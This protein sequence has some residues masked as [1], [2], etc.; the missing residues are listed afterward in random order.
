MDLY[1]APLS[2]S[3]ATRIALYESGQHANFHQVVLSTKELVGGGD[4]YAINPKGQVPALRLDDGNMLTEG[5]AILQYV[6]DKNPAAKLAP[7]PGSLARYQLQQWLNYI[8]TEIHKALFYFM[9]NPASPPE[10][11][12][13]VRDQL[14]PARYDHLSRHLAGRD[15]LLDQFSIADC[16]LVTTLNWAAPAGVDLSRWPVLAAYHQKILSRPAV[17]KAVSEEAALR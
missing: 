10:A 15:Y 16:Y 1:F 17:A 2:C 7:E 8:G 13:F 4:Y 3:L 14:L 12:A 6:A 11:K 5:P 9:F